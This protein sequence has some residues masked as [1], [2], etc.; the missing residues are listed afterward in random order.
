MLDGLICMSAPPGEL[1]MK[2]QD[3]DQKKRSSYVWLFQ[4]G[5][6]SAVNPRPH[7]VSTSQPVPPGVWPC[8][9]CSL[10]AAAVMRRYSMAMPV[11]KGSLAPE[12]SVYCCPVGAVPPRAADRRA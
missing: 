8:G 3:A 4:V 7:I 2:N 9:S 11:C 12:A 6:L 10:C 1:W 5:D